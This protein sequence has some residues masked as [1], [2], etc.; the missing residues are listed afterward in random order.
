MP[1][2]PTPPG[3][4]E[5][6]KDG[7]PMPKRNAKGQFTGAAPEISLLKRLEI[8]ARQRKIERFSD[9]SYK[10]FRD[11]VRTFGGANARDTLL[12][13]AQRTGNKRQ[14]PHI[15]YMYTY[16]YDAKHKAKLPY[17]D[18][19]PLIIMVGPAKGGFYGINLHYL[20]PKARAMLFDELLT[21]TNNTRYNQRTKFQ[22]TYDLLK[23]SSKMG[24][25]KPCF[26]HYLF[27]Q[28]QSHLAMIPADEWEGALFMPS[29]DFRGASNSKVWSDSILKI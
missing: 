21:I 22:I 29:A 13:D 3:G 14:R 26:K 15:G 10:W 18:A 11:K 20:P 1:K 16:I 24:A 23:S 4:I 9:K 5:L 28:V 27:S 2:K 19:F 6:G 17:W 25:F 8:S 12:K 7:L